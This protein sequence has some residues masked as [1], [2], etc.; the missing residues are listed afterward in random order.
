MDELAFKAQKRINKDFDDGLKLMIFWKAN[1]YKIRDIIESHGTAEDIA[2]AHRE[3]SSL[4]NE[5][6]RWADEL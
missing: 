5:L 1:Q 3:E 6:Q 4:R 2:Q